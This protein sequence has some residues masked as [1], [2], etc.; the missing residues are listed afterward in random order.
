MSGP[1]V[2][3]ITL[4]SVRA[5]HTTLDGYTRETTP[6]LAALAE[7]GMGFRNCI[8]HGKATLPSSGAI[9]TG[10]AP[11]RT[12]LGISGRMLP[13]TV[14]TVAERFAAAGYRTAAISGNS[15]VSDETGLDRGFDQFQWLSSST[16]R[17]IGLR[18]LLRYLRNI[19]SHSAGFTLDPTKHSTPFLMNE[20]AKRWIGDFAAENRPLFL[21]LHYNEPHRPYYPPRSYL[22]EFTDEIDMPAEAAAANSLRIH[23]NLNEI[24]AA[25]TDLDA[26]EWESLLAMYDAEI[27]YTDEMVGRLVD[28]LREQDLGETAVVV[29]ADHGELFGEYDLLSHKFVLHDA[30]TRVPLVLSGLDSELAVADDALI[31]HVDVMRTLL[32]RGGADTGDMLGVDLQEEDREFAVSQRGPPD[33]E[34]LRQHNPGYDTSRFHEGVLTALRT[35]DWKYLRSQDRTELF[36]LPDE[37]NDL[38]DERSAIVD[39]LDSA[40]EDWLDSHGQPI[41]ESRTGEFSAAAR[42]QLRELGYID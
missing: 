33:F 34:Q 37:M 29:T 14:T 18:I 39:R 38:S 10:I 8:A 40:L 12:G 1:N 25:G 5:D 3:W 42:R 22:R 28:W 36:E 13:E 30:L 2:V 15:F 23:R 6:E 17:S 41:G 4:D 20:L 31:Q 11:S 9:L 16:L 35:S 21:Y 19:R 7:S 32:E 27:A 26:D 24:V